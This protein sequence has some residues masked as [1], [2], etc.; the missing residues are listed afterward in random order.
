MY[1]PGTL[2]WVM[3]VAPKILGLIGLD[4]YWVQTDKQSI[5]S[6]SYRLQGKKGLSSVHCA[7]VFS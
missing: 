2:T 7:N 1:R 4:F 5:Y 6:K 3:C